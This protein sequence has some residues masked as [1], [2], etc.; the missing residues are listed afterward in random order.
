MSATHR[1]LQLSR[2]R[3]DLDETTA[4]SER[5]ERRTR[6]DGVARRLDDI[7]DAAAVREA[8]H[9]LRQRRVRQ[10]LGVNSRRGAE[11]TRELE[12]LLIHIHDEHGLRLD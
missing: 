1:K 9:F 8:A 2:G 6:S 7:V 4:H 12:P 3:A 5:I 10:G 11:L